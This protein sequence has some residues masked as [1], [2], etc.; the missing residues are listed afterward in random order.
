MREKQHGGDFV[1]VEILE[2]NGVEF[3]LQASFLGSVNA[4]HD[5][6]EIAPAGDFLE[7]LRIE[8]IE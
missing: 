2:G 1:F 4:F 3:D 7:F 6:G 8:R 5:L